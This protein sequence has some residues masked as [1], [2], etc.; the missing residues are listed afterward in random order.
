MYLHHYYDGQVFRNTIITYGYHDSSIIYSNTA[1]DVSVRVFL[2][3]LLRKKCLLVQISI[4]AVRPFII[5]VK[6]FCYDQNIEHSKEVQILVIF[7]VPLR[8]PNIKNHSTW[9]YEPSFVGIGHTII[10]LNN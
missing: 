2:A 6:R 8:G 5:V 3:I 9:G 4:T 10:H 1:I 7:V